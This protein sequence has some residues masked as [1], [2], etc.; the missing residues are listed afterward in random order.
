M[1]P[2]VE[3]AVEHGFKDKRENGE[4][5]IKGEIRGKKRYIYVTDNGK[6]MTE[7]EYQRLQLQM[8]ESAIIGNRHLGLR[9]VNQRL[10][11]IYGEEYGLSISK[12]SNGGF[13]V[14]VC[15]TLLD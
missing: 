11:L 1:Q 14:I 7:Q 13:C 9:N 3:N 12:P 5:W 2:L 6:G 8:K 4:I 15:Y 10:K